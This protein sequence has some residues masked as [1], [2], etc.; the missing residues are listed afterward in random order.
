MAPLFKRGLRRRSQEVHAQSATNEAG[1]NPLRWLE[2]EVTEFDDQ[3]TLAINIGAS[4]SAFAA[5]KSF[6]PGAPT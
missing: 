3:P 6:L 4:D 5:Y 1:P 2:V